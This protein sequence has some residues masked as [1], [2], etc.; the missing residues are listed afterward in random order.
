MQICC[1]SDVKYSHF[2]Q[3][4]CW[5]N[6]NGCTSPI[7]CNSKICHLQCNSNK[8]KEI[9]QPIP[10]QSNPPLSNWSIWFLTQTCRCVF[11]WLCQCH[12]ELEGDKRP[13]SFYLGHFSLSKNF[14]HIRKD[15]TFFHLKSGSSY[16][17]KYFLIS[18][19]SRHTSHHH[20]WSIASHQFLTYKYGWPSIGNWL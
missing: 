18:T 4:Y 2:S 8:R 1:Y 10:H 11:T 6:M 13:S 7:L 20:G 14:N 19:H 17:F 5:P 12:L 9:S 3:C 15:A 16:R